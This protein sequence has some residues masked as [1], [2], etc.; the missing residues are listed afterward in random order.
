MN[1]HTIIGHVGKD[2]KLSTGKASVLNFTVATTTRYKKQDGT[3]QEQTEWHNVQVWGKFAEVMVDKIKKGDHVL[4][5][6]E[7]RT[8]KWTDQS[9]GLVKTSHSIRVAGRGGILTRL[10]ARKKPEAETAPED[11]SGF[12]DAAQN[13]FD[14]MGQA[15]EATMDGL[16]FDETP[17]PEGDD[18]CPF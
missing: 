14:T 16:P 11:T 6:G 1:Q 5:Q 12:P 8:S 18:G 13:P 9:S 3:W 2:P 7:H 15:G 4:V 10:N 17:T